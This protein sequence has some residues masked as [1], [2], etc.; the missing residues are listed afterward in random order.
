MP[1]TIR[2]IPSTISAMPTDSAIRATVTSHGGRLDQVR[3]PNSTRAKRV[4]WI[5][6]TQ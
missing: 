1:E 3:G 5:A 6:V 2:P 4:I